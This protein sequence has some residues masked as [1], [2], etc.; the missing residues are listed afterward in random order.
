M[1]PKSLAVLLINSDESFAQIERDALNQ[2]GLPNVEIITSP[3]NAEQSL[4]R[5]QYD[6]VIGHDDSS[7]DDW[8]PDKL[9]SIKKDKGLPRV[10]GLSRHPERLPK[11][12]H[13]F[14]PDY[15]YSNGGLQEVLNYFKS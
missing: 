15:F 1:S 6:V 3:I 5:K 14:K 7:P 2:M 12:D 4:A 13:R 8:V 10:V 11:V 9:A